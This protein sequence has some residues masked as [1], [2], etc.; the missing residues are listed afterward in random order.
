MMMVKQTAHSSG[1]RSD[2]IRIKRAIRRFFAAKEFSLSLSGNYCVPKDESYLQ[3]VDGE[4]GSFDG[5]TG[6][7]DSFSKDPS[8]DPN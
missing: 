1:W 7:V 2:F 3:G 5:V 8:L 6:N 4:H